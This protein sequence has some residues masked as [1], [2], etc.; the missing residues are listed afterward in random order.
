M[1]GAA[2]FSSAP[3]FMPVAQGPGSFIVAPWS[4]FRLGERI[5]G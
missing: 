1:Q 3:F 5:H 2:G 4:R